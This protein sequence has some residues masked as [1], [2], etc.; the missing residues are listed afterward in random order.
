LHSGSKNLNLLELFPVTSLVV[1][2]NAKGA[3]LAANPCQVL[4][5]MDS[6]AEL[7]QL[8]KSLCEVARRLEWFWCLKLGPAP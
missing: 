6:L 8:N 5:V 3:P 2:P 4:K 7:L 1:C